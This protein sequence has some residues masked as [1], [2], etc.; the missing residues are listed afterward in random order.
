LTDRVELAYNH[1]ALEHA[2]HVSPL[3]LAAAQLGPILGDLAG[4]RARAA[5]AID[6]AA[7]AGAQLVVLP[8]LCTSGYS[9]ADADEARDAAE[10]LDGPAV[11]GWSQQAAA[12][13]IVVVAGF[14]EVDENGVLRN[15]AV[16]VDPTGLRAVYRKTHLWDREQLL[17]ARGEHP[18]PVVDTIAGRVGL[19]ICFDAAFPEHTRRLALL[20]ADLI[21]VPMN[22]PVDGAPTRPVAIEVALAMAA[23]NSNHVYV[24][25]ADRTGTERRTRWAEASVVVGPDGDVLAGPVTGPAVLVAD[26]DIARARDKSWGDRNDAFADRRPDLYDPA[27]PMPPPSPTRSTVSHEH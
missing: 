9:F 22:S 3:R 24:V 8:E 5:A 25:Q 7:A 19:A 27:A 11:S 18:A 1:Q 6:E 21:A 14:C 12:H 13:G 4:N 20:G 15:S 17:F 23:A 16:L 10:P 26:G 2:P